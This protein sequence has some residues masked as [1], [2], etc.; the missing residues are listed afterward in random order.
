MTKIALAV[1]GG[2]TES[3]SKSDI[4]AAGNDPAVTRVF[5]RISQFAT[6]CSGI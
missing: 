3:Y 6:S 5:P 4:A 1:W 2:D